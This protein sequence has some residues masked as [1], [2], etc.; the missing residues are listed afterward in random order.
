LVS[1]FHFDIQINIDWRTFSQEM[2]SNV[3]VIQV[4][5]IF[6]WIIR[7][8]WSNTD[9][10]SSKII[11]DW[12]AKGELSNADFASSKM[13]FITVFELAKPAQESLD[14]L[15]FFLHKATTFGS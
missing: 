15:R 5:T 8:W 2:H 14:S 10:A 6:D 11:F 4:L 9:K 3:V 13:I 12:T 1:Y 7:L